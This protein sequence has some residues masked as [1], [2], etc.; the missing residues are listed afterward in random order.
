MQ[1]ANQPMPNSYSSQQTPAAARAAGVG[2]GILA[3]SLLLTACITP[4][5]TIDRPSGPLPWSAAI[6][7][8]DADDYGASCSATLVRPDVILT[9]SHCLYGLGSNARITDFSFTPALDAGRERLTPV[10]VIAVVAMGWP[11]TPDSSGKLKGIAADDWAAL[12]I[13]PPIDYMAPLAIEKLGVRAIDQRLRSGA[14]LSHAG[15]GVYGAMAGKRLQMRSDC[16]L[17]LDEDQQLLPVGHDVIINSCEVIPGDSGGPILL[18][19]P[20][21]TRRVVGVITNYWGSKDGKDVDSFGP[22]SVHFADE[23]GSATTAATAP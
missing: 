17:I 6:G 14:S 22:S 13:A 20:D 3:V 12:R 10:R 9:A 4:I 2:A 15:F 23:I 18:T 5:R 7:R 1:R 21:G 19:E 16:R 11:I 8:L